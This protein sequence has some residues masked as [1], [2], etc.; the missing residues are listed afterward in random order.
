MK[1]F[2]QYHPTTPAH[3]HCDAC[4]R[5]LCPQC[6][7]TRDMGDYHRGEKR[8]LCPNCN[9][10]VTWL[11]VGNIIDPFWRRIPRFFLYPLKTRPLLLML[12]LSMVAALFK[13][14]GWLNESGDGQ[15]AIGAFNRLTKAHPQ[16]PLVPKSYFRAAQIFNDRLMN[17]QKA[18]RILN[19]LMKKFPEHDII[20]FVERYLGEMG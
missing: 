10:Q 9:Q 16:D 13:I 1:Q 5:V 17:P 15:A 4:G 14:G 19:G 6:V 20:P 11:G 18:K 3:W 2:C 7:D 12:I 8:H